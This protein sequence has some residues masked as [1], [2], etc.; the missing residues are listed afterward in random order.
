MNSIRFPKM[1]TTSS[2]LVVKD[3]EATAQ[4]MVLLFYS[5]KGDLFGDPFFGIRLKKFT[6]NQNNQ[7]LEQMLIDEIYSQI[8]VFMPQ[9]T[10]TRSN[11]K[12]KRELGRINIT[13]KA[14]NNIDFTTEMYNAVLLQENEGI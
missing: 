12:I 2:T 4:D 11:I 3:H 1:F 7:V 8:L 14:I 5:E 6:F 9:L 13:V 10:V